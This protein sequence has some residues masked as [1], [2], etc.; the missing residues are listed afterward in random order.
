MEKKETR[1]LFVDGI[2][3]VIGLVVGNSPGGLEL[4][5]PATFTFRPDGTVTVNFIPAYRIYIMPEAVKFRL[6]SGILEQQ[7]FQQ[8][9]LK[10]MNDTNKSGAAKTETGVEN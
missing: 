6:K 4:D 7:Y 10:M 3:L 1:I 9:A 8:L 5:D 2:G